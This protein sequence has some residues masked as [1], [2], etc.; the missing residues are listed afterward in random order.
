MRLCFIG[1]GLG[2]IEGEERLLLQ[3]ACAPA[4]FQKNDEK[5]Q[6]LLMWQTED[7]QT[8]VVEL[9][10]GFEALGEFYSPQGKLLEFHELVAIAEQVLGIRIKNYRQLKNRMLGRYREETVLDKLIRLVER[11]R[12]EWNELRKEKIR[13]N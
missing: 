1:V 5:K 12:K 13:K 6:A 10:I 7:V 4:R 2:V 3:R 11:V 8:K 9:L